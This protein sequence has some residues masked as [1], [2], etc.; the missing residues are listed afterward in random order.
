MA[1]GGGGFGGGG[2]GAEG[3]LITGLIGDT[4]K[5]VTDQAIDDHTFCCVP[6]DGMSRNQTNRP[7]FLDE[8][9]RLRL[10]VVRFGVLD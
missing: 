6:G 10:L 3:L 5:I 7:R 1:G 2:G 8:T 4:H 9:L